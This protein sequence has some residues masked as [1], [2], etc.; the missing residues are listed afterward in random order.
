MNVY[1]GRMTTDVNRVRRDGKDTAGG[2]RFM[3]LRQDVQPIQR[4]SQESLQTLQLEHGTQDAAVVS[5]C[6]I[7]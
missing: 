6:Y 2:V 7:S 4:H 3:A 5:D 1:N